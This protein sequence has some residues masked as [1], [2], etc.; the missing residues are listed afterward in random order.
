MV[1]CIQKRCPHIG[2]VTLEFEHDW[3][4][5]RR[6]RNRGRPE[7]DLVEGMEFLCRDDLRKS[8]RKC[9]SRSAQVALDSGADFAKG[10]VSGEAGLE[11][12]DNERIHDL[13][14]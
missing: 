5:A 12:W 3:V 2:L 13:S 11:L 8:F 10:M 9:P 1:H 14:P 4:F 6:G 7:A